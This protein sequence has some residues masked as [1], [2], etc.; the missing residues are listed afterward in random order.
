[1][2]I[3][4]NLKLMG[5]HIIDIKLLEDFFYHSSTLSFGRQCQCELWILN[6]EVQNILL[7]YQE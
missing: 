7:M 6:S 5:S 1:M 2:N 3:I 4:K